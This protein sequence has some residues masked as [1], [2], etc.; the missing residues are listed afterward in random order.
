MKKTLSILLLICFL[1]S[2]TTA[3]V[4]A[5]NGNNKEIAMKKV[6]A[7]KTDDGKD[8]AIGKVMAMTTDDGKRC[9]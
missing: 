1:M 3:I 6:V 8:I 7:I 4:S 9:V 2:V 5:E